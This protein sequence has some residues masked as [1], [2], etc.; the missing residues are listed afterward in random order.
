M[1]LDTSTYYFSLRDNLCLKKHFSAILDVQKGLRAKND[2][3]CASI[4]ATHLSIIFR[5][6]VTISIQKDSFINIDNVVSIPFSY[7]IIGVRMFPLFRRYC[8]VIHLSRLSIWY[9]YTES[10]IDLYLSFPCMFQCTSF[11]LHTFSITIGKS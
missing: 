11:V 2:K 7:R 5:F 6:I 4:K 1:P 8:H 3:F 9:N 10:D